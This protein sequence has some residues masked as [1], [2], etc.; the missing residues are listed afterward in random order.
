M[1]FGESQPSSQVLPLALKEDLA[2][3]TRGGPKALSIGQLISLLGGGGSSGGGGV[4]AP[5]LPPVFDTLFNPPGQGRP[6]SG[7]GLPFFNV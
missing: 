5:T 2:R 6:A 4:G 7:G 3:K 1:D